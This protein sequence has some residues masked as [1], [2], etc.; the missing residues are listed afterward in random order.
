MCLV[1][2]TA[3]TRVA[4]LRC[5]LWCAVGYEDVKGLRILCG[6][7]CGTCSDSSHSDER[8]FVQGL[9]LGKEPHIICE[10]P[11]LLLYIVQFVH[12]A[13]TSEH[14]TAVRQMLR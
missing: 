2:R 12:D 7:V 10:T 8:V 5:S 4:C 9:L 11:V 6:R 3:V 14:F 1:S 13:L